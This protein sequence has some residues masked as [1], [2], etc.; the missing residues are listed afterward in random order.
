LSSA[1]ELTTCTQV[2][3]WVEHTLGPG[4][5]VVS[6]VATQR[7]IMRIVNMERVVCTKFII[8]SKAIEIIYIIDLEKEN[9]EDSQVV[10]FIAIMPHDDRIIVSRILDAATV[11]SSQKRLPTYCRVT[12]LDGA[13]RERSYM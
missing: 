12:V 11:S 4:I 1:N 8:S 3:D 6:Q 7:H 9:I 5:S 13:I 10:L 2:V